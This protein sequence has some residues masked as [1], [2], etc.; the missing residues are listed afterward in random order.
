MAKHISGSRAAGRSGA[1]VATRKTRREVR[2]SR[3]PD[4]VLD[5][6]TPIIRFAL[7]AEGND[8]GVRE[9]LQDIPLSRD[10]FI[11]LKRELAVLR[12][13]AGERFRP[14]L[15]ARSAA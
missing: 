9:S 13:D 8:G 2:G 15:T 14:P 11:H 3:L 12:G 1:S 5:T 10:E 6:P 4:Y 7:S